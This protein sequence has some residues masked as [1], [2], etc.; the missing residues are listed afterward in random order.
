MPLRGK[1]SS[2]S[3][4]CPLKKHPVKKRKGG[5]EEKPERPCLRFFAKRSREERGERGEK[6]V[7]RPTRRVPINSPKKKS[8]YVGFSLRSG[9]HPPKRKKKKKK[10]RKRVPAHLTALSSL[11]KG[12]KRKRISDEAFSASGGRERRGFSVST[13]RAQHKI[14]VADF[15]SAKE[16]RRRRR[17]GWKKKKERSAVFGSSVMIKLGERRKRRSGSVFYYGFD[18]RMTKRRGKRKKKKKIRTGIVIS[19]TEKKEKRKI[20]PSASPSSSA[21]RRR[22]EGKKGANPVPLRRSEISLSQSEERKRKKPICFSLPPAPPEGREKRE[23][24][25]EKTTN[26]F[27]HPT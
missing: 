4:N 24:E 9:D 25:G 26:T 13:R 17:F 5:G 7:L 19:G 16:K 2:R 22:G 10:R 21:P 1:K 14:H 20:V 8:Q 18:F 3:L 23:K 15:H 6:G 27:C 12:L 11:T